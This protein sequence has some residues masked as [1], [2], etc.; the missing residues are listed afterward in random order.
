MR[1]SARTSL[2][3]F[4]AAALISS[5]A[6]QLPA[7]TTPPP[8]ADA[9]EA[10][11]SWV[12]DRT[13]AGGK[14]DFLVVLKEQA[15]LS[16]AALL[17]TRLEKT[18]FVVARLRE[19]AARSQGPVLET[20]KSAGAP[21]QS[22]YVVNAILTTGDRALVETL[23][24]RA[25]VRRI[26]G[27]PLVRA[28]PETRVETPALSDAPAAPDAIE[29]GIA[30]VGAPTVWSM[31][32][33]GTGVVAG[34]QDTGIEWAHPALIGK[35]RGWNGVT[36]THDFNW[37]AAIHFST[38]ICPGDS[39][40]P[41]DDDDHGTHTMGTFVG[42]DGATNQIGMAPGARWVGCR[43]MDQGN[44]TPTTYLEC[45]EF[46]LAPYPVGGTPAQ[47]NPDLSPDVTNNSWGCPTSEGC[48]SGNWETMRQAVAAHRAAGILTVASAGNSGSQC[49]TVN[50][51]PG[52][53]DES[54]SVGAISS[55]SGNIASFSSR[56][57]VTVDGSGRPKPDI[58]APGVS[59]RSSTTGGT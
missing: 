37:H 29:P 26:D 35:Y 14:T 56:G 39:L 5:A 13:A 30:Y 9:P 48:N 54:Y 17:N 44:G 18:R 11:S 36:A 42:D 46:F 40:A 15:D 57:P 12:L 28:R 23:A 43:N 34:G 10:I 19:A 59:V 58:S 45:F 2:V 16:G 38:G 32:Y 53:F 4:L 31:G 6:A 3:V 1:N 27:N 24:R 49:S 33:T 47:G 51:P 55:S 22:F 41:C 7:Q 52:M 20:L 21:A 8:P 25:D 50:D